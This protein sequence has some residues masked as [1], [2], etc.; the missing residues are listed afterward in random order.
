[1]S[2]PLAL[3]RLLQLSSVSLP[4]GGY[5]F[6]QGMEYAIECRWIKNFNDAESWIR[7]QMRESLAKVDLPI[8][9]GAMESTAEEDWQRFMFLNDLSIASRE[10]KEL[11][12]TDTAMGAALLRLLKSLD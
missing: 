6:S 3:S 1:M 4:V 5:A 10:T 9:R 2:N 7:L 12:L 11:R 8:L